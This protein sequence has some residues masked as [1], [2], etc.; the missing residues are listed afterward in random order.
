MVRIIELLLLGATAASTL[1]TSRTGDD[2]NR[3]TICGAD[4]GYTEADSLEAAKYLQE[5]IMHTDPF[6]MKRNACVYAHV[7]TTIV[8]LCN[9]NGRDRTVTR[10]EVRRG[11]NQL[12]KDCGLEGGFTG[13]HVVNNLTMGAFGVFGGINMAPPAGSPP[14]DLPGGA[15]RS[16]T[17]HPAA[18]HRLAKRDCTFAYD[19]VSHFDCAWKNQ[20]NADGSCA[21]ILPTDN[22]DTDCKAFCE[23]RRTG[24]L[25]PETRAWGKSGELQPASTQIQFQAGTEVAVTTSFSVS[26]EG[27]F[28]DVF[29]AGLGYENSMTVATSNVT[30]V[31]SGDV[32]DP[33]KNFFARWVFFPKLIESCGTISEKDVTVVDGP[34]P[35]CGGPIIERCTGEPRN[36]GNSCVLSPKLNPDTREPEVFWAVR[37]EYADGTPVPFEEQ[38]PGYKSLCHDSKDPDHDGQD[39][40]L[41]P[42]QAR[43]LHRSTN[44]KELDAR[45]AA[46]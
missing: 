31:S 29:G 45:M 22:L 26:I 7:N 21:P 40:C 46:A 33:A 25:G 14:P 41:T 27:V 38:A 5:T 13:A 3:Y 30:A 44:Y 20:L 15:K 2:P 16:D 10:S 28:K 37:W 23:L 17:R 1:V 19:G 12:I 34:C 9:G 36:Y 4:R 24:L 6:P 35:E 43:M 42:I 39:E 8:S 32:A 18:S 11:I